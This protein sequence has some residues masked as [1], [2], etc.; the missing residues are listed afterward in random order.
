VQISPISSQDQ[1]R[2]QEQ[3]ILEEDLFMPVLAMSPSSWA[4]NS[5]TATSLAR[6]VS[7]Q[8]QIDP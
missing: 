5:H 3:E 4:G 7:V 1:E 2:D 6:S 8:M